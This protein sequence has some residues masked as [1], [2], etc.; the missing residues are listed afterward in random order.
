MLKR[1]RAIS[2]EEA[3]EYFQRL[4]ELGRR[5]ARGAAQAAVYWFERRYLQR[6]GLVRTI[7][8]T[9]DSPCACVLS[10]AITW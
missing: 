3:R 2:N 7:A 8:N 5:G 4:I 1:Q 6:L 9:A 10:P